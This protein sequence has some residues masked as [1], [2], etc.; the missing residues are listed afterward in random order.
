MAEPKTGKAAL[1]RFAGGNAPASYKPSP[2]GGQVPAQEAGAGKEYQSNVGEA[3]F[4]DGAE[5]N[6]KSP[7]G[8]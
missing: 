5:L 3:G 2:S 1:R 6:K 7:F 8:G 4:G